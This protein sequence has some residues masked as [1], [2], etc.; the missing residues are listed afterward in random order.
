MIRKLLEKILERL[1]AFIAEPQPEKSEIK[2]SCLEEE[3][4]M[5]Q[6]YWPKG[7]ATQLRELADKVDPPPAAV[8][9]SIYKQYAPTYEQMENIKK[10]IL[11]MRK[12]SADKMSPD[13]MR[14]FIKECM[15]AKNKE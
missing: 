11:E 3:I 5:S 7:Y 9:P 8:M 2:Q 4:E 10:T 15:A 6:D 14:Y 13:E 1:L 12:T